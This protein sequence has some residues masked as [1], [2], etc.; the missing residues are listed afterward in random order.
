MRCIDFVNDVYVPCIKTIFKFYAKQ[1]HKRYAS[2][3]TTFS[4]Y[5]KLIFSNMNIERRTLS[6]KTIDFCI[7]LHDK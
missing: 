3:W 7:Y 1:V 5:Y 6:L 4:H 2:V